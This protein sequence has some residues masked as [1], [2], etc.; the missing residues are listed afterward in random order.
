M[1]TLIMIIAFVCIL[2]T[3]PAAQQYYP[4]QDTT[5]EKP[6]QYRRGI[7]LQEGYQSYD[8]K[9]SG[10]NLSLWEKRS[11]FPL[12]STEIWT[13]LNPKV[14][15]V[16]YIGIHFFNPDTGWAVGASGSI[17]VSTN[18]GI[19]WKVAESS[20]TNNLYNVHSFDGM[21]VIA[22]GSNGIILRSADAGNTW[23]QIP[24]GVFGDLRR[25]QMLNDTLGWI[26]GL[27]PTLL[28]TTNSGLTWI[29]VNTGFP[30][31][32][33]WSLDFYNENIGYIAGSGLN[34][35]KTTNKGLL[36]KGCIIN[37]DFNDVFL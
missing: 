21:V 1:R 27:G 26:C 37:D 28:K 9:Y 3:E 7:E 23:Q 17:I 24:G 32:D 35:Q 2:V 8:E 4:Q 33:Y 36:W 5:T 25:V 12:E 31:F 34:I 30:S 22:V 14:P 6:V 20:T 10:K 18:S 29:P 19:S 15:R 11:L 16:D 13:E